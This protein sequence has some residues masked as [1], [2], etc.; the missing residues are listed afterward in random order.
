MIVLEGKLSI[1]T[2]LH[3]FAHIIRGSDEVECRKW[4]MN[5]FR[6]VYPKQFARLNIVNGMAYK[7]EEAIR[8]EHCACGGE[9][10]YEADIA[11]PGRGQSWKCIAC[12]KPYWKLG[13]NFTPFDEVNPSDVEMDPSNAA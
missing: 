2:L 7:S 6:K 5:L 13:G 12:D 9:L 8:N 1:I 11:S 4:S 3:E 10:K